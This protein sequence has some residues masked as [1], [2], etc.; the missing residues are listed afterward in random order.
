MEPLRLSEKT[1]EVDQQYHKYTAGGICPLPAVLDRAEG[2]KMWH[3]T[4]APFAE[5]LCKRFGYD[6]VAAMTSGSEAADTACKLAR[7]W[8]IQVKGIPASECLILGVS[9]NY[10]GVTG[11]VWNLMDPH[12]KR[13][14][15]TFEEEISY[16]RQVY[17][18]CK[19]YNI[20]FIADEV[21][22]GAG[23]TGKF[24]SYEH[25]GPDVVPDIVTMG[26]SITGGV[27][28][29]SYVLANDNIAGQVGI[30]EIVS[31]FAFTPLGIAASKAALKVIDEEHLLE[32]AQAIEKHFMEETAN[33]SSLPYVEYAT[34]RGGDFNIILKPQSPGRK[35]CA[36]AM[37]RG[38]LTLSTPD[39]IRMSVALTMSKSELATGLDILKSSLKE[40]DNYTEVEG[41][42]WNG[43]W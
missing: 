16:A 25:L 9:D 35:I 28:P 30:L 6:K 36:L 10:H 23:K 5:E 43:R 21:R 40:V 14:S 20:L 12:E 29:A 32:K 38:V 22:M 4:W 7:R 26:K 42:E 11:G 39:R 2:S 34:A 37:H 15:K 19:K 33:W 18:L 31:T 41:E 1:K 24:F 13:S 3:S 27:Y 8:G 17:D